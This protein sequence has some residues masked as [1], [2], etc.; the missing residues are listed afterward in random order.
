[1]PTD[2]IV[3]GH[4]INTFPTRATE[5]TTVRLDVE[6]PR[7]GQHWEYTDGF[8]V[9]RIRAINGRVGVPDFDEKVVL[10]SQLEKLIKPLKERVQILERDVEALTAA[11]DALNARGK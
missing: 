10:A 9:V 4:A 3:R 6:A 11:I 7:F 1:M 5:Y 8:P 2:E